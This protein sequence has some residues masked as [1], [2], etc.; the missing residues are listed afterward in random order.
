MRDK[1]KDRK[2]FDDFLEKAEP[3]LQEYVDAALGVKDLSSLNTGCRSELWDTLKKVILSAHEYA[4]S[5]IETEEDVFNAV[6][7]GE[8]TIHHGSVLMDL[9]LT[10]RKLREHSMAESVPPVE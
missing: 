4:P 1:R 2:L 7:K 6:L 5:G 8:I 9:F 3:L 10:M